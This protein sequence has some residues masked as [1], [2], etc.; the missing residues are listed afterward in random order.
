L[1]IFTDEVTVVRVSPEDPMSVDL[2]VVETDVGKGKTDLDEGK[3]V[4]KEKTDLDEGK[5]DSNVEKTENVDDKAMYL[6]EEQPVNRN[7]EE[8]VCLN[9]EKSDFDAENPE[10]LDEDKTDNSGEEETVYVIEEKTVYSD[11][12]KNNVDQEKPEYVDAEKTA[13]S[14]EEENVYLIQEKT[15]DLDGVDTVSN[16]AEDPLMTVREVDVRGG[17]SINVSKNTRKRS[18]SSEDDTEATW[19]KG[20][21]VEDEGIKKAKFV[22]HV[23]SKVRLHVV[24]D[25]EAVHALE[26]IAE[27]EKEAFEDGDEA[28]GALGKVIAKAKKTLDVIAEAEELTGKE[29]DDA[30]EDL[31]EIIAEAVEALDEVLKEAEEDVGE[32]REGS[33]CED[34]LEAVGKPSEDHDEVEEVP[35]KDDG[36]AV[37]ELPEDS[38][39]ALESPLEEGEAEEVPC[40][41]REA[42]EEPCEDGSE[43]VGVQWEDKGEA[44]ESPPEEDGETEEEPCE[45]GSEAEEEPPEDDGEADESLVEEGNSE[46]EEEPC[47]GSEA[48]EEPCEDGSVGVGVQWEDEGEAEESLPE[49]D[50]ETE[51]EPCE[52][53]SEAEEEPGKDECE[54]EESPLEEDGETEE[55]EGS[56]DD[57]EA[58]E[59]LC[60]DDNEDEREI[61][62]YGSETKEEPSEDDG[63]TEESPVEEEDAE[64]D[65]EADESLAE[66]ENS[67]A[68]E[69]PCGGSE[70]GEALSEDGSEAQEPW[71]GNDGEG[72]EPSE[73]RS[74]AG[75]AAFGDGSM[76][77]EGRFKGTSKAQK[78]RLGVDDENKK[79]KVWPHAKKQSGSK[80]S[81]DNRTRQSE[82]D[83]DL[84]AILQNFD[85]NDNIC[86]TQVPF[87]FNEA[88][89]FITDKVD[90]H[91]LVQEAV[92]AACN[93]APNRNE[94]DESYPKSALDDSSPGKEFSEDADL[95]WD[96]SDFKPVDQE[97]D[98]DSETLSSSKTFHFGEASPKPMEA[99][100]E[101][102]SLPCLQVDAHDF[103][104]ATDDDT[105]SVHSWVDGEQ[106]LQHETR[107]DS[108][109]ELEWSGAFTKEDTYDQ[110]SWGRIRRRRSCTSEGGGEALY[111]LGDAHEEFFSPQ[112]ALSSDAL[113][114]S[115]ESPSPFPVKRS[116]SPPRRRRSSSVGDLVP[117]NTF[118]FRC[119]LSDVSVTQT[120][121]L[122]GTLT[123]KR[124]SVET[125][126]VSDGEGGKRLMTKV[127]CTAAGDVEGHGYGPTSSPLEI[128]RVFS[129]KNRRHID[130]DF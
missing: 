33:S 48:G 123:N 96:F 108:S 78:E 118:H 25:K 95:L 12:E 64:D 119:P 68:E 94:F 24:Q 40:E 79:E 45:V 34:L 97:V 54:A 20:R 36:D 89:A 44:G 81:E 103:P 120:V 67:E 127:S 57:S 113:F 107:S 72:Q 47:G 22:D 80:T 43:T 111:D 46:A 130:S 23:E 129:L 65:G 9:E 85:E 30:G 32:E 121:N 17:D 126:V 110:G 74:L 29:G 86:K 125:T 61:S 39:E 101:R 92:A 37:E 90:C 109:E 10:Y 52:V 114:Y 115:P 124:V 69:E 93:A 88:F 53:G 51:E 14:G 15:D 4:G 19:S 104:A 117:V 66:E 91:G 1:S 18:I 87:S 128:G 26:V 28:E 3:K 70:A 8:T 102:G 27:V 100:W 55:S 11:E 105:A 99:F 31:C 71:W 62:E 122:T 49:E 58:E 98:L 59:T 84:S 38:D 82:G 35:Q 56:E 21:R 5:T 63:E 42:G 16:D 7:E 60:E 6:N 77:E 83:H 41:V 73:D 76:A 75:A 106:L 116:P 13:F 2:E 50:G 112:S